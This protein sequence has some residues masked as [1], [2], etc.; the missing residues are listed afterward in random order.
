MGTMARILIDTSAIYALLDQDD[1]CHEVAK[2]HLQSLKQARV[3][4][5]LTNFIIAECHALLLSRLNAQIARKWLL[6]SIWSIER[7]TLQDEEKAKEIIRRYSDKTFSYTDATSFVVMER[8]K[9][10]R[11]LAF[12]HHFEQY[13]FQLLGFER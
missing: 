13:G 10:R 4:P 1:A 7:V 8:L 2:R 5:L 11:A 6:E 12:D 9:I 3:E